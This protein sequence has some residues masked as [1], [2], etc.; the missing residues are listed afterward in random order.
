LK[1]QIWAYPSS[2]AV[3]GI[4]VLYQTY[5]FALN[6]SPAVALLTLFDVIVIWSIWREYKIVRTGGRSMQRFLRRG[7]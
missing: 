7:E 3:F 6:H 1:G 4:F 5:L 2:L